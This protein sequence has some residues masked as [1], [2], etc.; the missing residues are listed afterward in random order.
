MEAKVAMQDLRTS[1][2]AYMY[3]RPIVR[4]IRYQSYDSSEFF[5]ERNELRCQEGIEDCIRCVSTYLSRLGLHHSIPFVNLELERPAEFLSFCG[6]NQSGVN[7]AIQDHV[8]PWL[9]RAEAPT[10]LV[11]E[12]TQ[13]RDNE[14]RMTSPVLRLSGHES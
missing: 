3:S 8:R 9:C 2:R 11:R 1:W 4:G 6:G 5:Q 13:V 10:A 7:Q 14:Q 12:K